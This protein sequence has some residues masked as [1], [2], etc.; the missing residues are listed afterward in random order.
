MYILVLL[1]LVDSGRF[2]RDCWYENLIESNMVL[3]DEKYPKNNLS[4]SNVGDNVLLVTPSTCGWQHLYV[5]LTFGM[6]VTAKT[7]TNIGEAIISLL[8]F[9]F[10]LPGSYHNF[11]DCG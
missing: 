7:V 8:L 9:S 11:E 10:S 4:Y 1:R 3:L 6:L 2:Q 5:G